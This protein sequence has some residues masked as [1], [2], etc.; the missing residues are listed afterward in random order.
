MIYFDKICFSTSI[1]AVALGSPRSSQGIRRRNI[2]TVAGVKFIC[3]PACLAIRAAREL[4][5]GFFVGIAR[6]GRSWVRCGCSKHL[7][8]CG[9][10]YAIRRG[11]RKMSSDLTFQLMI[12]VSRLIAQQYDACPSRAR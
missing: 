6:I 7:A 5:K 8:D 9:I 4:S 2:W 12:P 10:L 11:I 1:N 3:L